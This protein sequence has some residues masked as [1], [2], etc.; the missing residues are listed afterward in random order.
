MATQDQEILFSIN[1]VRAYQI[2]HGQEASLTPSGP[3]TLNLTTSSSERDS[4]TLH[5]RL[6]PDVDIPLLATTKV[7]SRTPRSYMIPPASFSDN[8]AA[9]TRIEFADTIAKDDIETFETILTAK[10]AFGRARVTGTPGGTPASSPARSPRPNVSSERA[11]PAP[12]AKSATWSSPSSPAASSKSSSNAPAKPPRPGMNRNPTGQIVLFDEEDGS[13]M[14]QLGAGAEVFED[15]RLSHK[16]KDSPVEIVISEDGTRVDVREASEDY[17]R[18]ARDPKYANS[19]LVQNAAKAS[20]LLVTSSA[21]FGNFLTSSA[22]NYTQT[23]KPSDKPLM[24]SP[25]AQET[26]NKV[27]AVTKTGAT[28]T[29]QAVEK[30]TTYTQNMVATL[31]EETDESGNNKPIMP[32]WFHEGV[33]ALSTVVDGITEGGKTLISESGNAATMAVSH[34]Y[35]SDAGQLAATLGGGLRNVGLVYIDVTGVSPPIK[36]I[37]SSKLT[38][39]RHLG[40]LSCQ[41]AKAHCWDALRTAT[42]TRPTS[43]LATMLLRK[44]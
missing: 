44:R 6:D 30:I 7:F 5:L 12:P 13:V 23:Q 27:H 29:K 17:L 16:S 22:E 9:F 42:A 33:A 1:N 8:V 15:S 2:R 39:C 4:I 28:F 10:T 11:S 18:E 24:I 35:G 31:V 19:A 43:L 3:Q 32:G 25:A 37:S 26:A 21:R 41:V 38:G 14:G 34:K 36:L 40:E 20:R